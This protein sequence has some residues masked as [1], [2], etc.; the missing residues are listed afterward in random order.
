MIT[1]EHIG[2]M[3]RFGN[4]L[5][6]IAAAIGHATEKGLP[7]GF[8]SWYYQDYFVNPL[9][10][11]QFGGVTSLSGYLQ[12]HTY[13]HHCRQKI[14][15]Y[16]EM[17]HKPV[18]NKVFIHYR[19][20]AGEGCDGVHPMQPMSYYERAMGEFPNME[21]MVF[22]DNTEAARKFFGDSFDYH[23]GSE[24]DAFAMMKL[25]PGAICANSSFSWW[26]AYL[27]RG[28]AVFP[29]RWYA[30]RKSPI[31]ISGLQYPGSIWL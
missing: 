12:E 23:D 1:Y 6:Q 5:F 18:M 29:S 21:F 7:Y 24:I 20:Y 11:L 13:F 4:Q 17:K 28:K 25:A 10:P 8:H 16:F 3:G 22:S 19:D 31:D 9:P 26:A 30:G 27:S 15:H 14:E 2:K